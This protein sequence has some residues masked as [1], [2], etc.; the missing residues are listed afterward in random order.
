MKTVRRLYFYAV[1]WVSLEVVLWGT[2]SLLRSIVSGMMIGTA[3]VLARALALILVGVPIFLFHWLWAQGISR[4]E[5]EEKAAGLRALFLYVVMLSTLIPAVQNLLALLNRILLEVS[6][7]ETGRALLGGTQTAADNLIA[8]SM[9]SVIA[10]YFWNV[11][12][13][14]WQTLAEKDAFTDVRRLYRYVWV[15]YGLILVILGAQQVLR[16]LFSVPSG[17]LGGLGRETFLN[18]ATL[19]LV[20]TPLWVYAW[21][22]VQNSL[23]EAAEA[24]SILR[25]VLLYLLALGGVIT[26]LT[27][28]AMLAHIVIEVLLGAPITGAD[29]THRLGG[30]ISVGLPF[31]V[32]WAYYGHWLQRHIA[33]TGD[34]ARRAGM[35]RLYLYALSAFGLGGAF[36][37]V[38][39]LVRLII[40]FLTTAPLILND[41]LRARL[42]DALSLLVAWLPL[43]LLTWRPLQAEALAAGEQGDHA[44]RSIVRKSYLYLTLFAGVMGGMA[45]AVALVFQ[46]IKP[47]LGVAPGADFLPSVLNDLQMVVLFGILLAYHLVALRRDGIAAARSLMEKQSRFKVLVLDV[48]EGFGDRVRAALQR[49][50]PGVVVTVSAADRPPDRFDAL[51]LSGHVALQAPPWIRSFDGFRIIVPEESPGVLWAG[52]VSREAFLHAAQ[53]VRLLAEG[54]EIRPRTERGAGWMSLVYIAAALFG[55]QLVA[56]LLGLVFASLM[57][58]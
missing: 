55:V 31:A 10:L 24:A 33:A 50:A 37:G 58:R 15:V 27:T 28:A 38:A 47:L 34:E 51:I 35:K 5:D 48:G 57:N 26:V 8:I 54:Q 53:M 6:R 39:T 13:R 7:V 49:I 41:A 25:L 17:V 11:L 14:E 19:L 43:W 21:R 12:R 46:L 44:R 40:D 42:A 4:R 29:F 36:I 45:S 20:G 1:A 18:G 2:I 56:G 52:G 9:N 16:F 30:P 23:Q 22:V 32:V 3:E